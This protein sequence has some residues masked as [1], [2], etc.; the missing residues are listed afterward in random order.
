MLFTEG[1][2]KSRLRYSALKNLAETFSMQGS[3]HYVEA[4]D[5]FLQAAAIDG[6]D[7]VLWNR[8]GTLSCALGNLNV[9]RRA[10]EEGLR[11][12]PRHCKL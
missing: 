12:S 5:C 6:K 11:C 4:V 8:L 7:V 9:A 10:F 2:C 1:L 3:G